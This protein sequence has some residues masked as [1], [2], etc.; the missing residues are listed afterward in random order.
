MEKKKISIPFQK[1]TNLVKT[2]SKD[3]TG[4]D[5]LTKKQAFVKYGSPKSIYE[6]KEGDNYI[7]ICRWFSDSLGIVVVHYQLGIVKP[8]KVAY[9]NN[10]M[11]DYPNNTKAKS[12]EQGQS[13]N[14]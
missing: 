1:D 9:R 3:F 10:Y 7:Q 14:P 2:Y 5:T 4:I 8:I 13:D 11:R 12:I 6:I